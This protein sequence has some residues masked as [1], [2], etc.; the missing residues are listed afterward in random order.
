MAFYSEQVCEIG[1]SKNAQYIELS[2]KYSVLPYA[3]YF[4]L[5]IS[6]ISVQLKSLDGEVAE[7]LN[8][9]D[10]KSCVG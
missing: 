6:T 10:S 1:N 5:S 3:Q 4:N 9:H 7:W 2:P 8:V